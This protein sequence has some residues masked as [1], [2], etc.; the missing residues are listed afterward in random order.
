MCVRDRGENGGG[1]DNSCVCQLIMSAGGVKT[2]GEGEQNA[3]FMQNRER[4]RGREGR[5]DRGR[6]GGLCCR[7]SVVL[8]G[9]LTWC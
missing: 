5:K 2:A 6:E 8:D 1:E 7:V 9:N 3:P 4:E